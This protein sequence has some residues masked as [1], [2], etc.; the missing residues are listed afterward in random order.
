LTIESESG[1]GTLIT[2]HL[3]LWDETI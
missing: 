1:Q 2:A 3:P